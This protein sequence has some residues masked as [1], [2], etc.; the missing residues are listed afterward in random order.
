MKKYRLTQK[1]RVVL[2]AIWSAVAKMSFLLA[3]VMA[4]GL[5]NGFI[6]RL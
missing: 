1:R 4:L 2:L 6:E 3:A 5:I